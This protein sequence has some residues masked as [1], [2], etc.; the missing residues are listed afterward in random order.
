MI[1][2]IPQPE[3]EDF[4]RRVR[5]PGYAWLAEAGIR[6]DDEPP[7]SN[8]LP[9]YWAQGLYNH[10]LWCAYR[11]VCAY[12]AIHFEFASGAA[13]TDHYVAKSKNA[14]AAYEWRNYRLACIAANRHKSDFEDVLD[15]FEIQPDTFHLNLVNG[16][17]HP[18]P[19]MAPDIVLK[20]LHTIKRL[21]LDSHIH[22][23]MRL[24]HFNTYLRHKNEEVLKEYSPFVW[25]EALRQ[26]LL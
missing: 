1:Q 2:V 24:R 16:K 13:S 3:P 4:D 6:L 22:N 9:N 23:E 11:G 7:V 18:N 10:E 21:R 5:Q 26:G 8:K 17:I 15:P 25:A 20:A 12:L 19:L 14:G